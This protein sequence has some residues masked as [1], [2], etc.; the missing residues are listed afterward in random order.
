VNDD[1][2]DF[3]RRE[4]NRLRGARQDHHG[5]TRARYDLLHWAEALEWA[6]RKYEKQTKEAA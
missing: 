5:G 6:A 3:L 2:A 4:A 1:F